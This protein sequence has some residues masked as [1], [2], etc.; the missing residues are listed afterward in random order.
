MPLQ[1]RVEA[2]SGNRRSPEPLEDPPVQ[3]P[4]PEPEPVKEPNH[5]EDPGPSEDPGRQPVEGRNEFLRLSR[6]E[7]RSVVA[8]Y[9]FRISSS[10]GSCYRRPQ[11]NAAETRSSSRSRYEKGP[12]KKAPGTPNTGGVVPAPDPHDRMPKV[13]PKDND[14]MPTVPPQSPDHPGSVPKPRRKA[15]PPGHNPVKPPVA[16]KPTTSQ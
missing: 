6:P 15:P 3:E 12:K 4:E 1:M 13:H 16:P 10:S 2:S 9:Y 8:E 5:P 11:S 14:P 7:T